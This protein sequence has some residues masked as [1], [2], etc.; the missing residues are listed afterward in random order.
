MNESLLLELLDQLSTASLAVMLKGQALLLV[1]DQSLAIGSPDAPN[2]LVAPGIYDAAD[3]ES[4]R[5]ALKND[6][7]RL[8]EA[9]YQAHPMS[10]NGF[11]RQVK[12][13]CEQHGYEAFAA[14]AGERPEKSLF[15]EQG[16]VIAAGRN[17]PRHQYGTYC[18]LPLAKDSA[19][20]RQSVEQ[21]IAS[22]QAYDGYL[23]MNAGQHEC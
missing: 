16:T 10:W 9:Y 19:D 7:D 6:A 1:D 23:G 4:L 11:D 17:S 18:E 2:V 8:N 12:L 14:A 13:L 22:G 21:W 3:A 15:V 5:T 20:I